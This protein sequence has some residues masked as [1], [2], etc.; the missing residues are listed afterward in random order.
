MTKVGRGDMFWSMLGALLLALA[1]PEVAQAGFMDSLRSLELQNVSKWV[2]RI[3]EYRPYV[4]LGGILLVFGGLKLYYVIVAL[5]GGAIG[6][7]LGYAGG[8]SLGGY[9]PIGALV[10]ALALAIA[11]VLLHQLF[12]FVLSAIPGYLLALHLGGDV[13]AAIVV[14]VVTGVVGVLLYQVGV[15]LFTSVLGAFFLSMAAYG[16]LSWW[17]LV[18]GSLAGLLIQTF[19][20]SEGRR[21]GNR[22]TQF[23]LSL[24]NRFRELF[25]A[26]G[27]TPK[28]RD[29]NSGHPRHP[30]PHNVA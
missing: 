2:S 30:G 23:L 9:G 13:T 12:V 20:Y 5:S 4:I 26:V 15:I 3:T 11:A 27:V 19:T 24:R 10:G 18:F 21:P 6:G 1:I 8:E 16:R 22:F 17:V 29:G 14:A 28:R 7:I 25:K